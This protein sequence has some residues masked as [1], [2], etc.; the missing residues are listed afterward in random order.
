M[1]NRAERLA[2]HTLFV[3]PNYVVY[4][5]RHL[6]DER[7]RFHYEWTLSRLRDG[8]DVLDVGVWDGWLDMLLARKGYAV[9]GV[10]L[11]AQ[12]ATAAERCASSL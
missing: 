6:G 11:V 4:P 8:D 10:E 12:L 9:E 2:I 3:P 7:D 1:T 5:E